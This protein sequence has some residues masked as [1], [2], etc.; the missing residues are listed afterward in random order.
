MGEAFLV[1]QIED[2][3]LLGAE[4]LHGFVDVV[5]VVAGVLVG[6]YGFV[7]KGFFERNAGFLA[8]QVGEEGVVGDAVE[9]T[10]EAGGAFEGA[11][12][13][14]GFDKGVL[15][16]VVGSRGVA[17]GETAEEV[18]HG[19]LVALDELAKGVAIVIDDDPQ[20]Q[21]DIRIGRHVDGV[22]GESALPTFLRIFQG[23]QMRRSDIRRR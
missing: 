19:G 4:A 11:D 3:G 5:L 9:P 8:S 7:A 6:L 16:E 18:A 1:V 12:G 15:S 17:L 20:H 22:S 14:V 2:G 23:R 21:V 10:G 13:A